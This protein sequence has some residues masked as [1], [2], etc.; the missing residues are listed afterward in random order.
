MERPMAEP[1]WQPSDDR[2]RQ[3][4]MAQFMEAVEEDWNVTIGD[5]QELYCFS[6]TEKE[7]DRKSTR[8]NSS[9]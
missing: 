2:V 8:L 9:H 6:I 4:N 5:F 1:I 3:T 7:K